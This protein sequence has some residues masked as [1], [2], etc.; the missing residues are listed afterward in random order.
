MSRNAKLERKTKETQ[1]CVF[2]EIDGQGESKVET[3]IGFF[4]HM[5]THLAKHSLCNLQITCSGDLH[6]DAHHTVEDVGIVLGQAL[7]QAL[8]DKAGI[9]RYGSAVIPMDEALVMTALDISGRG[10]MYYDVPLKKERIGSFDCELAEEFFKALATNAGINVHIR[11]LAGTNAHHIVEAAFK[12][13]ARALRE[14]AALDETVHGI[15]STK[16]VL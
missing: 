13:F 15:P 8:G 7:S 11:K 4:D 12:S 1:V 14:A 2:I 3:G 5:L 9:R 16:G 10:S 6:V